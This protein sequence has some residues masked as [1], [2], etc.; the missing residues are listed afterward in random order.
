M[1]RAEEQRC[2]MPQAEEHRCSV[3]Q[4]L[5]L[6]SPS[7]PGPAVHP[8][9]L[10]ECAC[11]CPRNVWPTCFPPVLVRTF[12]YFAWVSGQTASRPRRAFA[13][14]RSMQHA[15]EQREEPRPQ[16]CLGLPPQ[17]EKHRC[18]P[19]QCEKHRCFPR[20]SSLANAEQTRQQLAQTTLGLPWEA[21]K[22]QP[23]TRVRLPSLAEKHCEKPR[24]RTSLDLPSQ[25]E[26]HREKPRLRTSVAAKRGPLQCGRR[27]P[28]GRPVLNQT[29]LSEAEEK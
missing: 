10:W 20:G 1:Q 21:E 14:V 25:T 24:L 11:D 18:F 26:K 16:A 9:R 13:E 27:G 28:P 3:Q 2:S 6:R 7:G 19:Q 8:K 23:Q 17:A 4:G 15:E 29:R 22:H 12:L 5:E